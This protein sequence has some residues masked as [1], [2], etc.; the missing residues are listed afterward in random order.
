MNN[1]M[2]TASASLNAL[3]RK[4]DMLA[5]NISNSNTVGY[6]RKAAAFEDILTNMQP[7]ESAFAQPGRQTPSGFTQG[8]GARIAAQWIDLSQGAF[9]ETGL[10]TDV[11]IEGN[12][13]FEVR[14]GDGI[15]S[16]A[17]YTRH[18][19][20]QLAPIAGDQLMLVTN[21]GLPVVRDAGGTDDLIRIP[22]DY[23]LAIGVDGSLTATDPTGVDT[24]ALGYLKI[25]QPTKPE[26]LNNIGENLFGIPAGVTADQVVMNIS[27]QIGAIAGMSLNQ[28]F[29][30][31]SNVSLADE[32]T[33]LMLVQRAYQLSARALTS[34]DQMMGMA[35][36]LRA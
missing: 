28:G 20:F 3:Q 27:Q 8:W 24:L 11:A 21:T 5:D 30:E 34:G 2:I 4:L 35:N 36:N 7:H 23:H 13:L 29:L 22:A 15:G 1:S 10:P 31:A 26:L 18:G 32:L 17:A 12:G 6:K 9:Q 33:D 16:G 14:T 25:V 19:S